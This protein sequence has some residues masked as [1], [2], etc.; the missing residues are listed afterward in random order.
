MR[1]L[2]TFAAILRHPLN[3]EGRAAALCRYVRWQFGSRIIG[4]R[5]AVKWVNESL[6]VVRC[7]DVGLTQ[8]IYCGLQEFESMAFALHALRPGDLFVDIGA[9]AGAYSVLAGSVGAEVVAFEP[10]PSTYQKLLENVAI[11]Q[12]VARCVNEGVGAKEE[13]LRF[14][15][16]LDAMNH[17]LADLEK[18]ANAVDVKVKPLDDAALPDK[19]T[20]IKIDVEGFETNV[21]AGANHTLSGNA[22][23]LIVEM[24]SSCERYGFSESQLDRTIFGYGFQQCAYN[25]IARSLVQSKATCNGNALY[26]KDLAMVQK[27]ISEARAFTVLGRQL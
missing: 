15:A 20:F 25:P 12:M 14:S 9:N 10:V 8:N 1:L 11:N 27:R 13:V 3:R 5:I 2:N 19:P 7:G 24:N 4:E 16:G 26:V 23:A 17:A 21:I 22:F 6:L 18:D